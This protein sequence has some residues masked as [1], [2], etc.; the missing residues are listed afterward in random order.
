MK[1]GDNMT[2]LSRR[3]FVASLPLA[4][5]AALPVLNADDM[6]MG[7][8]NHAVRND[9]WRYIHYC[10][11]TEELY[12]H[13]NDPW[14]FTN[15]AGKPEHAGVISEMKKWLPITEVRWGSGKTND[16]GSHAKKRVIRE[17]QGS[18]GDE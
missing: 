13:E 17:V 7:E 4:L 3:I 9:R 18:D 1:F 14:E 12:D 2:N 6:T 10:D 5:W 15:L 16:Q 8:G 11:G